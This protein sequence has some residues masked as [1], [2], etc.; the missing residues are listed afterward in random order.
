M[1]LSA[2]GLQNA[3]VR[4]DP[5]TEAHR[6]II[7]DSEIEDSIW[8]W[9]PALRG[10]SNLK[11]YFKY[12]LDL[13]KSGAMATF[14]LFRQSDGKFAGVTGFNEI[15]KIHRR[16][17]NALAW[18]PPSLTTQ[19]MYLAGQLAMIERAYEWRAKR[20]EW[21]VNTRNDYILDG[22]SAIRPTQEAVFRNFERNADGVWVDKAVF[23]LTRPEM[24]DAI[25]RLKQSLTG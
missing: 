20:I 21:Q 3:I 18:H 15:N 13:Q 17:R 16:V 6:E 14:V 11:N 5:I 9:M 1:E 25:A 22:L 24:A 8:K 2:P 7:F 4:L 10:G 12:V 23:S 19:N